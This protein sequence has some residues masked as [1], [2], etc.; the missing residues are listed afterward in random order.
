MRE[1]LTHDHDD[2]RK[3]FGEL[4]DIIRT[5]PAAV[6]YVTLRQRTVNGSLGADFS[7]Y[8]RSYRPE[9]E[10]TDGSWTPPAVVRAN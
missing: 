10:I 6:R 7:L 1:G 5:Q 3:P 2:G 8:L 4:E 9:V